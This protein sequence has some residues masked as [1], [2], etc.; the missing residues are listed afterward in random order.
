MLTLQDCIDFCELTEDEIEAIAEHEHIPMIVAAELANY[1]VHTD[2]G[3]PRIRRI[4][5]DDIKHARA[6]GDIEHAAKLKMVLSH[7]VEQHPDSQ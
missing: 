6:R 5:I 7:F 3:E 2:S 1:L 4:I